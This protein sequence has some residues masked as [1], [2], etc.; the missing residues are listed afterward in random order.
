MYNSEPQVLYFTQNAVTFILTRGQNSIHNAQPIIIREN[1]DKHAVIT[2]RTEGGI[3]PKGASW[4]TPEKM[5]NLYD[6]HYTISG[7]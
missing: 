4:K 1:R 3:I 5:Y 2:A 6:D 7:Y